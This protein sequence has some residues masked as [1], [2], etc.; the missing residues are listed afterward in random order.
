MASGQIK[1]NGVSA[2]EID[3][4]HLRSSIA[5][6]P[7]EVIL[8]AGSI[9]ENI[10]FG[11]VNAT[12]EAVH[13]AAKQANALEFIETFPEGMETQV[14]DRGIQLSGGQQ[15][16]IA[17]ARAFYHGRNVLVMDEATSALD[18]ET[19]HEIVEEIRKLHGVKTLIVIAHRLTTLKY[20][21]RIFNLENGEIIEEGD[22]ESIIGKE[23]H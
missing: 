8:F 9:R 6:V 16:R 15:Q 22:H 10:L 20:C 1:Y 18:N 11:D 13:S 7:Q 19:E 17:L 23:I 4:Y 3:T 5:I 2:S 12:N 21:D 14:G